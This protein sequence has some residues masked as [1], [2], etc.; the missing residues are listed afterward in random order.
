ML[1]RAL[2]WLY[3]RLGRKYWLVLAIG[4]GAVS[5]F[6]V[7]ASLIVIALFLRPPIDD[8]G[9]LAAVGS[10]LS[11]IATTGSTLTSRP[12]YDLIEA[13]HDDPNPSPGSTVTAWR[14]ASTLVLT[15][16]R[17]RG[18]IVNSVIVIPTVVLGIIVLQLDWLGIL[19]LGLSVLAP[20]AWG[21]FL[22][23][24]AGEHLSRPL[25]SA[26]MIAKEL[27]VTPGRRCGSS[28]SWAYGR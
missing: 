7:V 11:V 14:A 6:V 4:Q 1:D 2:D 22:S 19:A 26:G 20:A 8:L 3:R 9:L 18:P 27:A 21:T 23:Y 13:W 28:R 15:Q 12:T 16:Y 25:V 17:T 5:I 10:I 24:S